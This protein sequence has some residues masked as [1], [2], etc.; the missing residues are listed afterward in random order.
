MGLW[1]QVLFSSGQ[2]SCNLYSP[3]RGETL[4]RYRGFPAWSSTEQSK[5]NVKRNLKHYYTDLGIFRCVYFNIMVNSCCGIFHVSHAT[6]IVETKLLAF[7][8]V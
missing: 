5:N 4:K 2:L 7:L 3:Y 1:G 8:A 6:R